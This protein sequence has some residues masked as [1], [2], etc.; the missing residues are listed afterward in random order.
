MSA[1][2]ELV[3]DVIKALPPHAEDV[4]RTLGYDPDEISFDAPVEPRRARVA[5]LLARLREVVQDGPE[6]L[7]RLEEPPGPLCWGCD[8]PIERPGLAIQGHHVHEDEGF[9][10][11]GLA[12]ERIAEEEDRQA[13]AVEAALRVAGP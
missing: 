2:T 5:E 9:D 6:L 7:S 10:C 11:V 3:V 12:K 1:L 13:R 8:E 4:W